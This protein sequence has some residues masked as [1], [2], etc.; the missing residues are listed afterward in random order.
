MGTLISSLPLKQ[1]P[2]TSIF[3][4]VGLDSGSGSEEISLAG[5]GHRL[6][7]LSDFVGD[8]NALV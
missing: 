2:H 4:R 6:G 8:S 1:D 5:W 3:P 7:D